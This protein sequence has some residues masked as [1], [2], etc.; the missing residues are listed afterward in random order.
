[1]KNPLTFKFSLPTKFLF[2]LIAIALIIGLS[3]LGLVQKM[4]EANAQAAQTTQLVDNNKNLAKQVSDLKAQNKESENA[5]TNAEARASSE[6]DFIR[7]I[8][9]KYRFAVPPL[10]IK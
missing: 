6:C 2:V 3:T 5:L 7:G 1:M 4:H 9:A 10:C 8:A